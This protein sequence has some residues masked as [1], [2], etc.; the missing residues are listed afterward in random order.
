MISAADIKEEKNETEHQQVASGA[1]RDSNIAVNQNQLDKVQSDPNAGGDVNGMITASKTSDPQPSKQSL[2]NDLI[3]SFETRNAII[4]H[5]TAIPIYLF[6]PP[7]DE[8]AKARLVKESNDLILSLASLPLRNQSKSNPEQSAQESSLLLDI[9]WDFKSRMVS[10]L[11]SNLSYTVFYGNSVSI[12]AKNKLIEENNRVINDLLNLPI[13]AK[14]EPIRKR[15]SNDNL[16][17]NAAEGRR[18]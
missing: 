5:L 7:I 6:G 12:E 3:L 2:I 9:T 14:N 13:R 15:D 11:A 8:A 4:H 16:E 1:K 17:N 10:C 18:T